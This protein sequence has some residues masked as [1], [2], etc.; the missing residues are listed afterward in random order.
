VPQPSM[1]NSLDSVKLNSYREEDFE[2]YPA[3]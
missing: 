3:M 2:L 1:K